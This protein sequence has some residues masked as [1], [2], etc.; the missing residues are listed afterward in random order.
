MSRVLS[1]KS[2]QETLWPEEPCIRHAE[3]G[4]DRP[5][6]KTPVSALRRGSSLDIRLAPN[7]GS[8]AG[9]CLPTCWT[10]RERPPE[11]RM[12]AIRKSV[13]ASGDEAKGWGR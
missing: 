8:R 6:L 13:D 3:A 11:C 2:K 5:R 10:R 4:R 1:Q 12:A 7:W 9:T